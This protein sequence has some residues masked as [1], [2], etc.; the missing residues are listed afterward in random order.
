VGCTARS[1]I[2][3]V[4]VWAFSV[5][6]PSEPGVHRFDAPGSP[7]IY[8]AC[9]T[10]L[11]WMCSWHAAQT[12]RVLRRILAMS[13]AHAGWPGPVVPRCLSAATWWTATVVPCSHSSPHRLRSRLPGTS[14][15]HPEGCEPAPA[16][17]AIPK[18]RAISKALL[19]HPDRLSEDDALIV[20]NATAGCTRL[21]R[22]QQHVRPFAKIMAQRRGQELPPG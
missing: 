1:H 6:P 16:V 4:V 2:P 20:R 5:Q 21:E 3:L 11:A 19:T 22:L 14:R 8:A 18:P 17:P 10:G 12:M 7:A 13:A 15:S 9:V